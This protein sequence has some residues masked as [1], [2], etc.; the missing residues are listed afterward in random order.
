MIEGDEPT[1]GDY[2]SDEQL[3]LWLISIYEGITTVK[4]LNPLYYTQTLEVLTEAVSKVTKLTPLLE[5]NLASFAAAKQH[6]IVRDFTTL[7]KVA[8]TAEDF[9]KNVLG[10]A[11]TVSNN[12]TYTEQNTAG[13]IANSIEE[14]DSIEKTKD[15][16]PLLKYSAILDE[17]TRQDHRALDGTV[18]PVDDPF[19]DS[20][21]PPNGYNCRCKV[22][23][24][25]AD[26]EPITKKPKVTEDEVPADF[27]NN[28][29]KSGK[30]FTKKHP[31]YD[32][33]TAAQRRDNF[34]FG[35]P[36]ER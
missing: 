11:R 34:G 12:W 22:V 9:T 23:P 5:D 35:F 32:N 1:K 17:R 25:M 36:N 31:Y 16:F 30:I 29:A 18:R 10:N 33:T 26:I 3:E 19:W 13:K 28:P 6:A 27:R 24:L 7:T 14:W 20:F 8:D 21:M 15:L 4:N 2:F